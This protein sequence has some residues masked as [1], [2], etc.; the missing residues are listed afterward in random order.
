MPSDLR[1]MTC[2]RPRPPSNSLRSV[3]AELYEASILFCQ[4]QNAKHPSLHHGV[5]S[6]HTHTLQVALGPAGGQ[7]RAPEVTGENRTHK[8]P[9]YLTLTF[10]AAHERSLFARQM[11]ESIKQEQMECAIEQPPLKKIKQE[12]R[13]LQKQLRCW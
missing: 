2:E 6:L 13:V 8:Q 7:V 5:V 11:V 10:S 3:C 4:V 12:V 9:G 1:K